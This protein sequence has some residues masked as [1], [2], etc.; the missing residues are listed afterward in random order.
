M[1]CDLCDK[2]LHGAP[3]VDGRIGTT[4]MW[5]CMCL[6]CWKRQG[7]GLFGVGMARL[8]DFRNVAVKHY[9]APQWITDHGTQ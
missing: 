7:C 9:D 4:L 5:A 1:K 3:Y 8:Y 2:N 6:S